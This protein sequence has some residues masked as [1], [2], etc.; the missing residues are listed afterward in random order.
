MKKYPLIGIVLITLVLSTIGSLGIPIVD[1]KNAEIFWKDPVLMG[2]LLEVTTDKTAYCLGEP[3]TIFL[4]NVGD[5]ILSAGGPIIT[6]YNED[7]VIV[8]QDACYCHWELEPEEYITWPSWDQ[9]DQQGNQVPIGRYEVEGF[10]SNGGEDYV[11]NATFFIIDHDPSGPPSGPTEGAVG[12]EYTFCIKL[13]DNSECEPY[14]LMWDWGDGMMSEWLG[15]YGAGEIVCVNYSWNEPGDYEIRVKIK[16][17]CDDEYWSDP[18]AIHIINNSPPNTPAIDGSTS[19]KVGTSY[20]YTFTAADL[21]SAMIWYYIDWDDG[22]NTGWIGLYISSQE[23]TFNHTWNEQGTYIIKAKAKD[24][25]GAESDWGK[26]SVTLPRNKA[27]NFN[28]LGWFLERFPLL[29]RLLT[30]FSNCLN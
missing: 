12:V 25:Y 24:T 8:Y 4:T 6:I 20:D 3:V 10:L 11:D 9:T 5:E 16:D 28:L 29:E 26:L 27:F 14:Y 18:L 19:G 23:I 13:P 15:P 30:L 21:E 7:D 17:S 2:P 22:S 1:N